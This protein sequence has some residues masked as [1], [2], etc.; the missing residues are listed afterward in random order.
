M[1]EMKNICGK[2]SAELHMKV[3]KEIEE[4]GI[5]TQQF[6]QEVLEQYFAK[7]EELEME[8]MPKRTLSVQV[9]EELFGRF[10]EAVA[11]KGCRQKDFLIG[12]IQK[13][14]EEIEN[15]MREKEKADSERGES[16]G[17]ED[18]ED[19]EPEKAEAENG[20]IE[21]EEETEDTEEAEAEGTDT[22]SDG[23]EEN[24]A[25]GTKVREV[26]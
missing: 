1:A 7:R 4:R 26:A 5:S 9:S 25:E 19:T 3:R 21:P 20:E 22:L 16:K 11:K 6:M 17:E 24:G 10:K 8:N 13:A 15:E 12:I 23:E 14:V 2:I 18:S